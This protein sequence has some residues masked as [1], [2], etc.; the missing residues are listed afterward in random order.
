MSALTSATCSTAQQVRRTG[1]FQLDCSADT[2]FPLFSPEGERLWIETWNPQPIFPDTIEFQPDT[3]F[4]QGDGADEAVWTI[5]DVDWQ[6]HRAE[7]VRVA[8]SHAAHIAVELEALSNERCRV[9][10]SYTLTVFGHDA[11]SLLESFSENAF[12]E[13]MLNWQRWI[14]DY[15]A[16]RS[17]KWKV[18]Y[19][20]SFFHVKRTTREEK[21]MRSLVRILLSIALLVSALARAQ[22]IRS[23]EDVLRAMHD[24]YAKTWYKTVTFTQKSTTYT[25]DGTS[26]AETWYE[27]AL[28]PGKLRIDIAPLSNGNGYIYSGGNLSIVKDNKL[29]ATRHSINML[30]VLGFDVYTQDSATTIKV[31]KEEGYDLS[32]LREDTWDAKPVY[33]VGANKDD[34][35]SRQFWVEKDTLL[36]VR[37]IEPAH[38]DATKVDDIRFIH[39]E[40][41]AG[42]WIA[43][44]VEVYVEGKKVFSEDYTEI[45]PNVKLD[46]AVFDAQKFSETHWEK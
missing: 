9:R 35:K 7:Y 23:G 36:F 38:G 4:R 29:A 33:V 3:I 17:A 18:G 2:A 20:L 11:A 43:A 27:A 44:G 41:L 45:Q 22:E 13:R 40:P 31:A 12:A 19:P 15:R 21:M 34:L 30:L 42:A 16:T 6:T 24:R 10:V 8:G 39:Y 5:V 37:D 32:K 26:S 25:P 14:T 46:P 1:S 28:L